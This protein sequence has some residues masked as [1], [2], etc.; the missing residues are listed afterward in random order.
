[1]RTAYSKHGN[2]ESFLLSVILRLIRLSTVSFSP[3]TEE[4]ARAELW[5]CQEPVRVP[6]RCRRCRAGT[7]C[8]PSNGEMPQHVTAQGDV[9]VPQLRLCLPNMQCSLDFPKMCVPLRIS[10]KSVP[11]GALGRGL[12][13][14]SCTAAVQG[15]PASVSWYTV[16]CIK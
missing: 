1:M 6:L 12:G 16:L 10:S 2:T 3:Q 4:A 14:G 9:L 8:V 5:L 7:V 13:W 11:R 15:G